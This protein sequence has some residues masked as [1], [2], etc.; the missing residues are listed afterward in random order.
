MTQCERI[1]RYMRDNG[2]ITSAEAM[3]ELGIMRLASRIADLKQMGIEVVAQ[4][5]KGLNRFGERTR[6]TRYSLK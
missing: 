4:T 6:F 2:S 1:L 5:E 3:S